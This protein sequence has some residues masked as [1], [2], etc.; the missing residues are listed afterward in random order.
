MKDFQKLLDNN[1][2]FPICHLN[3]NVLSMLETTGSLNIKELVKKGL[4]KGIIFEDFDGPIS[5]IASLDYSNNIHLSAAYCQ[6]LWSLS[7]VALRMYDGL[8]IQKEISTFSSSEREQYFSELKNNKN[9]ALVQE[10]KQYID[11]TNVC[12]NCYDVFN[13]GLDLITTKVDDFNRYYSLPNATQQNEG[14]INGIYCYAVL[15]ILNH[16]ISHFEL[17]H[18]IPNKSDEVAADC[19]A[20]WNLYSG[21]NKEEK[22]SAMIGTLSALCSLMFFSENMDGDEQHPN[23]D[24]RVISV[25]TEI[26][27]E[28]SHYLGFVIK[29]FEMWGFYKGLKDEFAEIRESSES[30]NDYFEKL[31]KSISEN[32]NASIYPN[33]P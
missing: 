33:H 16:E 28:Y 24:E 3:N 13:S 32:R 11:W 23:E 14:K 21:T 17:K 7:Y 2:C 20:F 6:L 5:N 10:L 31:I 27:D 19:S 25:L 18:T 1:E 30:D 4:G 9:E 29:L 26:K 15:F 12:K 8:E 22:I